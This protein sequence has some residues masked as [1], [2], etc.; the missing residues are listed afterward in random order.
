MI[1]IANI[2]NV[3]NITNDKVYVVKGIF[4]VPKAVK[5]FVGHL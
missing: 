5:R 4:H 3:L 2:I 1:R